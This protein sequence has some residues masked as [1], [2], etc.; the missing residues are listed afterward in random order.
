MQK[1]ADEHKFI[2][3]VSKVHIRVASANGVPETSLKTIKMEILNLQAG[4]ATSY[5]TP[6]R[7]KTWP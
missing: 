4:A 1:E 6:E 7:K 5:S 2:T 3:P